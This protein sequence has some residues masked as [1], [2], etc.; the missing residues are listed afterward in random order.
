VGR[1]AFNM[2][3]TT[4]GAMGAIIRAEASYNLRR[5]VTWVF[6]AV[7]V[8]C[9][10]L[11]W[12]NAGS[13]GTGGSLGAK[14]AKNSEYGLL[15]LFGAFSFILMHFT[16]TFMTDPV[17][18]DYRWKVDPILRSAPISKTDYLLGKFL[19]NFFVLIGL[20]AVFGLVLFLLQAVQMSETLV[21][22]WRTLPYIKGFVL[23]VLVFNFAL[24]AFCFAVGTL[25]KSAKLVYGIVTGFY[26]LYFTISGLTRD[27]SSRWHAI[28][29]PS[30]LIW[31]L[32]QG[33]KDRGV[34]WLNANP[35]VF[36]A[37]FLWNRAALLVIGAVCFIVLFRRFS[38]VETGSESTLPAA[39]SKPLPK[40]AIGE[41][42]TEVM[43]PTGRPVGSPAAIPVAIPKVN[44]Q[45]AGLSTRFTQFLAAVGAELRLLRAE[46]SLF[47][48]VP[49]VMFFC[50]TNLESFSGPFAAP[51]Y[52]VSSQY[53]ANSVQALLVILAGVIIFYTGEVVHRDREE[54]IQEILWSAPVPDSLLLLSKF[55]AMVLL[56]LA[57]ILL[58]A[59]TALGWQATKH[60]APV[61]LGPYLIVY[62]V[63]LIP[64]MIFL[65]AVSLALNVILRSKYLAY[66]AGIALGAGLVFLF[67]KDHRNWVYNPILSTLWTYSDM[68][69]LTP[70]R[71]GLLLHRVYW[72]AITVGLLAI[73]HYFFG[74]V[75]AGTRHFFSRARIATS[76]W[77][78][79]I[80]VLGLTVAVA[81]G[82]AIRAEINK[83]G[84]NDWI[85]GARNRYEDR[86]KAAYGEAPQPEWTRVELK[87]QLDPARH[88]MHA[89]GDFGLINRSGKP[90][91][92][93]LVT[94]D[95]AYDWQ[96]L[97]VDGVSG[98]PR[99]DELARVFTFDA[100][101][102]PGGTATLHAEWD[103]I[104]PRGM[105][106][107][108]S[109]YST[110]IEEGGSFLGAGFVD[111]LPAIGYQDGLELGNEETRKKYGK[112]K[113]EPVPEMKDAK[114][115]PAL[116]GR[117][118]LAYD[119]HLEITVP[120]DQTAL[121]AGRLI[122]T[123]DQGT[124]RTFVYESDHPVV[125]F[126]ILAS[127][128][129]ERRSGDF[130]I[131]YYPEH[132]FNVDKLLDALIA[133]RTKYERDFGPFPFRDL[134]IAEFP[135][136]SGFAQGHPTMIPFSEG[137]G[138]LTRDDADHVNSN[139][140]VVA[141]E[142]GHQ[143]WGNI[144]EPGRSK[145]GNVLSEGLA[146]Y[147]A[148]ALMDETIGK[149]ATKVFRKYEEDGYLRGR[150]VDHEMPLV[151][152]DDSHPS[153]SAIRYQKAGM[154]FHML[155]SLI[156]RDKMNVALSE[157]VKR[158]GWQENHPT[159]HN[160]IAI[161]KAQTPDG[162]IDYFYDQWF[163]N[164]TL[165]DFRISSATVHQEGDEYVVE[166]TAD[167]IGQG[168]L[169]VFI[170]A[171]SGDEK[172]PESLKTVAVRVM[173]EAGK[174]TKG[175][176]RCPFKPER[177][178]LDRMYDLIDF[179]RANNEVKLPG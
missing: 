154:V 76:G 119:T 77:T 122:K 40:P 111:W 101:M 170:E 46:R 136:L 105:L 93:V 13:I 121:S 162:S 59:L 16:A 147:S 32:E 56:S 1:I 166:F 10:I 115:V 66:F 167:N 151:T 169:P 118:N 28:L 134:R 131:Y 15:V 146:E 96:T 58:T 156:G 176:I 50:G 62:S 63:I 97:K 149:Q 102:Q 171:I 68:T 84:D 20:Y 64:S 57:L 44:I 163:Y 45:T 145:G 90:I 143:W 51:L 99:V 53:A 148:G 12:S 165:P 70:Y 104:I 17:I 114:F 31:M 175:T 37:D 25:T 112:A 48:M 140:F 135:R 116:F 150:S 172:H 2:A 133:S 5:V 87:V 61:E 108:S 178:V 160:L 54:R 69:R 164:I 52:P 7:L 85:E 36:T 74:R 174:E 72:I 125:F 144:V 30:G 117:Q 89:R 98:P 33:A 124:R 3:K 139:Y 92:T 137:I 138:F 94:M 168:K 127:R 128:Y 126:P 95:P 41:P 106:R 88:G 43:E 79:A 71:T 73:T 83:G 35:I 21:L 157:Y 49:V 120:S 11:F 22:P 110:F 155:E 158:F 55:A 109:G 29:D 153:H 159:I 38:M 14:L 8:G 4:P 113:Q 26:V 161:L 39:K 86:F 18:R 177:V 142:V 91:D 129:A 6:L 179:E 19:G 47:I 132:T 42:G 130:A 152:V 173:V 82:V 34:E 60:L 27:I 24:A 65:V 80:A 100:P 67:L 78:V 107:Q 103:A 141:H 9:G 75:S 123:L 23:F 81:S